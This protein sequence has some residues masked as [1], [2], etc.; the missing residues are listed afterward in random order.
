[1]PT[2]L[3]RID[4][5]TGAPRF[6]PSFS[7]APD[8]A[9]EVP[10]DPTIVRDHD[11]GHSLMDR[12]Q[13]RLHAQDELEVSQR[14][15][16]QRAATSSVALQAQL[17]EVDRQ[18][19]QLA[20]AERLQFGRRQLSQAFDA[21]ALAQSLQAIRDTADPIEQRVRLTQLRSRYAPFAAHPDLAQRI[22]TQIDAVE[23]VV[24]RNEEASLLQSI[25]AGRYAPTLAAARTAFPGRKINTLAHPGTG[26]TFF[27]PDKIAD[28]DLEAEALQVIQNAF[29]LA[30]ATGN[31]THLEAA[32]DDPVVRHVSRIPGNLA[33][34]AAREALHATR[35]AAAPAGDYFLGGD[36]RVHQRQTG[37]PKDAHPELTEIGEFLAKRGRY[38]DPS[39]PRENPRFVGANDRSPSYKV[40]KFQESGWDT[41]VD[42]LSYTAIDR[43]KQPDTPPESGTSLD[44]E[45]AASPERNTRRMAAAG[46]ALELANAGLAG[47]VQA[48]TTL[49]RYALFENRQDGTWF[50]KDISDPTKPQGEMLKESQAK[51]IIKGVFEGRGR[52]APDFGPATDRAPHAARRAAQS[53]VSPPAA[54]PL[55]PSAAPSTADL[56]AAASGGTSSAAPAGPATTAKPAEEKV[57]VYVW[58]R[59]GTS[60]GHV[61]VTNEKGTRSWLSQFPHRPDG[62]HDTWRPGDNHRLSPRETF[63]EEDRAPDGVYEVTLPKSEAFRAKVR[64]HAV[65]R[66]NWDSFPRD[67]AEETH[68]AYSSYV[69]LVAGGLPLPEN[70]N[71]IFLPGTVDDYLRALTANSQAL[72]G[73]GATV[74]AVKQGAKNKEDWWDFLGPVARAPFWD[75]L[76]FD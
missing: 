49:R 74:K 66:S 13:R 17:A 59:Q 45:Y 15:Q 5:L 67:S 57:R 54:A 30:Q 68:C 21:D 20:D 72:A 42:G 23:P 25:L 2:L 46:A 8:A 32:L 18:S 33:S 37:G 56:S 52:Q 11:F 51:E 14:V 22:D 69:A 19:Q 29:H 1:M 63:R 73:T 75:R 36:Y 50:V 6:E 27:V 28:P 34:A 62:D 76:G 35:P 9:A 58:R 64:D 41:F 39:L 10:P 3:P 65:T 12:A 55:A 24:Q 40:T 43:A 60:P 44:G 7:G 31:H 26:A 38:F 48:Q 4:P 70:T 61:M 16:M 47:Q 53:T 71:E